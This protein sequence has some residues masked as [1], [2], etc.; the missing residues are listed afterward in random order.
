MNF[1]LTKGVVIFHQILGVL[2]LPFGELVQS[3]NKIK[4]C[5][6]KKLSD[7]VTCIMVNILCKGK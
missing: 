4:S 2:E 7:D 5:Q 3:Y 6:V 1:K